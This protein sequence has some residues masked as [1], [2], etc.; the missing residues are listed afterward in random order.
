MSEL[1]SKD[2]KQQRNGRLIDKVSIPSNAFS[3]PFL[4][5]DPLAAKVVGGPKHATLP[6]AEKQVMTKDLFLMRITRTTLRLLSPKGTYEKYLADR[7][8]LTAPKVH[9]IFTHEQDRTSTSSPP[10][11]DPTDLDDMT[12]L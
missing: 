9:D 2:Q 12:D 7:K 4:N 5:F 10:A 8:G 3:E 11:P 6:D 1:T